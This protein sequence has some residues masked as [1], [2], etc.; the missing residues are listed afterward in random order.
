MRRRRR[1]V[2]VP[3]IPLFGMMVSVQPA[4][5]AGVATTTRTH[6]PIVWAGP[7]QSPNWS[8]YVESSPQGGTPFRQV[9]G[10]W[11]VPTASLH[12]KGKAESSSTWVGIGGWVCLDASCKVVDPSL[13]Q[14]G[15]NQDVDASGH[16]SY[17]A[18]WELLPA[19]AMTIPGMTISPGDHIQVDIVET[20]SY[21]DPY[22]QMWSITIRDLTKGVP[23]T[24]NVPYESSRRSAEW[25]V[26]TPTPT[27]GGM[28]QNRLPLP[29]LTTVTFDM[30][31]ANG[32]NAYLKEPDEVKLLDPKDGSQATPSAPGADSDG[33]NDCAYANTCLAPGATQ[34]AAEPAQGGRGATGAGGGDSTG[35]DHPRDSESRSSSG[36]GADRSDPNSDGGGG[37]WLESASIQAA[38]PAKPVVGRA[39]FSG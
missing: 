14:A 28:P 25:I 6:A 33:F 18:W 21:P 1:L 31:W 4:R 7:G 13:I 16:P 11:I 35:G 34:P 2:L 22:S 8:G 37:Q 24:K 12:T 9:S 27:I 5:A 36:G 32:A 26:E 20:D 17:D 30:A 19:N 29:N 3:F 15:T 10:D 23:F 38:P 39:T